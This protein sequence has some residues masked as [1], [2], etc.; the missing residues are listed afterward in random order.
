MKNL[1][2][3]TVPLLYL[4]LFWA[5]SGPSSSQDSQGDFPPKAKS[6]WN[7]WRGGARDSLVNANWPSELTKT[8]LKKIWSKPFDSSYS[9]PILSENLVFTTETKDKKL[10]VVT[11]LNKVSGEK[12]WS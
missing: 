3:T 8:N 2:K 4:F 7:Q 9:G 1:S 6:S 10:E 11:A 12:V 5:M